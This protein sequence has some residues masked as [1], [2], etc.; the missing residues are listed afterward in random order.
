MYNI[1]CASEGTEFL[2]YVTY[3]KH[4]LNNWASIINEKV[5]GVTA[6]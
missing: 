4:S 2:Q 1:H 3:I 5:E 6:E